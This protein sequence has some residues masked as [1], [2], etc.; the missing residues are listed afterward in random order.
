M[1]VKYFCKAPDGAVFGPT[2]LEKLVEWADDSRITAEHLISTDEK[3]WTRAS[4]MVELKMAYLVETKPGEYFGPFTRKVVDDLKS[5][6]E[7]PSEAKVYI[8]ESE[9]ERQIVIDPEVLDA[10]VEPVKA[11]AAEP[12]KVNPFNDAATLESRLRSEIQRARQRGMD[13]SFLKRK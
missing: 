5:S 7:M 6:G 2:T 9:V 8:A 10:E 1:S 12:P 3:E 13:F 11:N 4:A